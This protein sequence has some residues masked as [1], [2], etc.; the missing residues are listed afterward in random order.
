M[1]IAVLGASGMLGSMLVSYL[2]RYYT[3]VATARR[4]DYVGNGLLP[5]VEWRYYHTDSIPD[6]PGCAWIINAIGAIPQQNPTS[7]AYSVV[8]TLFPLRLANYARREHIRVIQIATDCVYSG[9]AGNYVEGMPHDG[10]DAYGRSK[11]LGEVEGLINLRCSIIGQGPHDDYSLLGWFLSQPKNTTV[12]GYTN[13]RWNGLTTLHFAKICQ[14]VIETGI[15]PRTQ[16]IIPT[17]SV[18]KYGLLCYFRECFRPD[19]T[20]MPVSPDKAVDQTLA[21]IYFDVNHQLWEEVG[22]N[23]PPTIEQMVKEY[24][25]WRAR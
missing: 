14:A 1:K 24:A 21:T 19:V 22:Y 25:E 7:K 10:E 4:R 20:V 11:S 13:H 12:D 6:F 17:G 3:V 5:A 9:K 16:H 2:S 15:T 8:N 23:K 18:S